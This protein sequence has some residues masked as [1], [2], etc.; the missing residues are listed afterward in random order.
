M[1]CYKG[2]Y[3]DLSDSS[4][5]SSSYMICYKG[6]YFDCIWFFT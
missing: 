3:F 1:I 5:N 6:E 2:E 4:L